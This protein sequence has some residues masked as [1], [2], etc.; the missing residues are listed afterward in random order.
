M[1]RSSKSTIYEIL[2]RDSV[3]PFPARMAPTLAFDVIAEREP[4]LRVLD[5]MSGS[6]T[7][8]AIAR[9][10][11]HRTIGVD[12]DPLAVLIARVWT[13][14]V[15]TK[16]VREQAVEVLDRANGRFASLQTRNAYPENSDVETKRFVRYWYDG[17]ARRQLSSLAAI[18]QEIED[19]TVRE[20][21]WCAFSRLIITKQSGASLARDLSHSRPHRAFRRAPSNPFCKFLAAIDRVAKNCIDIGVRSS[22]PATHVHEGDARSLPL[23]DSSIDLV[24][25]SPPYL[26]AI[27]YFRC[28]KFSLIWMGYSVG[29]LRR[30]RSISVGTEVGKRADDDCEIQNIL[31]QLK[32]Q[33]KLPTRQEA[34][35][36]RY[37]DDIRAVVGETARVLVKD[38]QAVFVVGENTLRGTFISNSLVVEA[39]ANDA[40]LQCVTRRSRKLPSNRRYLPPPSTRSKPDALSGRMRREVILEFK[41]VA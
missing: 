9:S 22:G 2:G 38:G 36:T 19:D 33:P 37:I 29:E 32:L 7:V 1:S 25:T 3:H 21:L 20:A 6:G 11:G 26:N 35:L 27:D 28:S 8:L 40:G 24:L 17:Y 18:I 16:I 34:I 5:P 14:P 31:S 30:L 12:I 15:D 39:I 41:K 23:D 13:T 10:R 4:P